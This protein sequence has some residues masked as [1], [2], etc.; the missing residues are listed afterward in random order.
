MGLQELKI[1]IFSIFFQAEMKANYEKQL[2]IFMEMMETLLREN[3]GG[4]GYFVGDSV[5]ILN[6]K[7]NIK[8]PLKIPYFS[9]DMGRF[10]R[11]EL[12]EL[13]CWIR[14]FPH[15]GRLSQVE[16]S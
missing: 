7:N 1:I 10:G 8:N 5:S 6:L 9:A 12:V 4:D 15:F 11:Y 13:D 16:G 14:C 2:P 3:N